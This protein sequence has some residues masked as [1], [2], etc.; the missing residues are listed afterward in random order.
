ML[1]KSNAVRCSSY[2]IMDYRE[3]DSVQFCK[4]F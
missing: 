1:A 2:E 4:N 3:G